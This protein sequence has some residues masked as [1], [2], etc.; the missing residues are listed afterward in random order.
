MQ[1]LSRRTFAI[2]A[3]VLATTIF[4]GLN[5]ATDAFVTNARLDLTENGRFTLAQGTRNIIAKLEEPIT[6]RFYYSKRVAAEYAQTN[7]YASRVRDLLGEYAALGHGNIIVQEIDPQPFTPEEDEANADGLTPAPTD[8]GEQV[9]FGLV[10]TNRID[11]KETI[12]YFT[13][14]REP[15]LEYDLTSLIYRLSTPKKPVI[16]IISSLPLETGPGGMAA[17]MQGQAQ[18]FAT[19][20]ELAQSYQTEMLDPAFKRVPADVDV[21]MIA[22]PLPLTDAQRYAIDQFVL[23]GGRALVFVDPLSEIAQAE[24]GGGMDPQA[25]APPPMSDLPGL[26]KAW[27]IAFN[28]TKVIADRELAQRVQ[29]AD[30]TNPV[31]VYP[32]WLHLTA[33]NGSF[34][35]K[36]TVTANLQTLNLASAGALAPLRGATTSFTPLASSSNEAGLIDSMA[37]RVATRP[38]DL[39]ATLEPTGERYAIAARISGPAKTAFPNGP[40]ADALTAAAPGSAPPPPLRPQ[41]KASRTGINV[42]VMADSDIFDD[43]FWV[44]VENVFGKK[45]AAPFADNAAFV[46]NAVENLSGSGDLISLRTRATNDRPFTVV[47]DLQANAEKQY[48]QEA[49]ALKQRLTDTQQQLRELEQGGSTNG[50]PSES[51]ALTPQQQGA[52]ARFKRVLVETRAELRDVQHNL[53]KD[54]DT[55]G[56]VLA[57]INIALVPLC[58]AAFAIGLA[59]LRARRRARAVRV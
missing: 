28:P 43:R 50:K 42:I 25:G 27:G 4:V 23:G 35:G 11:G 19:Y 1:P 49:E 52:I 36:D 16:G 45:I 14:E 21:L 46:L 38:Q 55:L 13:P 22:H 17:A 9:Y 7:S 51:T 58:V 15:Y 24:A 32:V 47:R 56:S 2:A 31:A 59:V 53:R 8:T 41:L 20:T 57:F 37:V 18:P 30:P 54:I 6:L 26:F 40:P 5:I 29:V 34:D 12:A 39:M 44:H 33:D 10:G 48:Q 3:L